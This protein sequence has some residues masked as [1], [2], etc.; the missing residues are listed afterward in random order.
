MKILITS[1][2]TLSILVGHAQEVDT[3]LKDSIFNS[4]KSKTELD[5][6]NNNLS[7][8][9][10]QRKADSIILNLKVEYF[11]KLKDYSHYLS[12]F[13]KSVEFNQPNNTSSVMNSAAWRVFNYA[14]DTADLLIALRW[15]KEAHNDQP[16]NEYFLDTY[17]NVLYKLGKT[18]AALA[19]QLRAVKYSRFNPTMVEN[20]FK[21]RAG[22]STWKHPVTSSDRN[23]LLEEQVWNSIRREFARKVDSLFW[24]S[25]LRESVSFQDKAQR[26]SLLI[27]YIAEFNPKRNAALLNEHA[28]S[29][30]QFSNDR[31]ELK[32][33][34]QWSA[35]SLQD[36]ETNTRYAFL[37][38]YAN[39]LYKLGRKKEAIKYAA[40]ALSLAPDV[41]R[42]G[43]Q[44]TL[45]K[46]KLGERTW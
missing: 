14:N 39:L 15:I 10:G 22:L 25:R 6:I 8:R 23:N 42:P 45:A 20:Y 13:I 12:A 18:S 32:T 16:T 36:Q 19:T 4:I 2:I 30:F 17:A 44:S 21:M 38:T 41:E 33:A 31:T 37:D 29:I 34:L 43:Y 1:S 40:Q 3:S 46:M 35:K 27:R 28:W 24:S 26:A 9:Y 7:K 11:W 5:D